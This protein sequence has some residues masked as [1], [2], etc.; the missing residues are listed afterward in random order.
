MARYTGSND[1]MKQASTG[2]PICF[3]SWIGV[4]TFLSSMTDNDDDPSPSDM[5]KSSLIGTAVYRSD[6]FMRM[7][8]F[9][10][11]NNPYLGQPLLGLAL[12]TKT[13]QDNKL[14]ILR[15]KTGFLLERELSCDDY[16]LLPVCSYTALWVPSLNST[17]RTLQ[18]KSKK[19]SGRR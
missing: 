17:R 6:W 18:P 4:M 8:Y 2:E 11:Y 3:N 13:E 7:M 10:L 5:E 19:V 9:G 12:L 1:S 14:L 16:L 15:R